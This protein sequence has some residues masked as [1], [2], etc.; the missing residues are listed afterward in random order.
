V[1]GLGE[2]VSLVNFQC[3]SRD[4]EAH[5]RLTTAIARWYP[6]SSFTTSCL[7]IRWALERAGDTDTA[8]VSHFLDLFRK[9][10]GVALRWT[11]DQREHKETAEWRTER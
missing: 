10:G 6:I 2:I 11:L 4:T 1:L 7:V 5:N 3:S 9:F 8:T